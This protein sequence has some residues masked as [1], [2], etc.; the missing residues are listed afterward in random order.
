MIPRMLLSSCLVIL[1]YLSVV[2]VADADFADVR[3]NLDRDRSGKRGDP[4][5]KYFH[6]S[7]FHSHYDGRFAKNTVDKTIRL[8][9]L[10]A[11]IRTFLA[12][13][14]DIGAET[15]IMHG[16]LLGWWWNEKILPWDSDLDLQ[17]TEDTI[18]FLAKYYNMT[19]YRYVLS[20][21]DDEKAAEARSYLLEINP[22]FRNASTTDHLNVID[23]RW[24]DTTT[25]LYID[26]S[27]VHADHKAR[28]K[29]IE[30][31]LIC[32]DKH[33]YLVRFFPGTRFERLLVNKGDR[34]AKSSPFV[35]ATSKVFMSRSLSSM[36]S[37]WRRNM[38][39]SR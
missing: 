16:T 19:E 28:K 38:D 12:T 9:H 29:G 37:C 39:Q 13:M 35:L 25:G 11:L 33:Q 21:E 4:K 26:I 22:H 17:V 10:Q 36:R 8:P 3:V 27:T 6:E 20:T 14:T 32:K 24:I 7:T 30:G 34:K 5:D 2:V 18:A 1:L 31:A 15:W 23:A